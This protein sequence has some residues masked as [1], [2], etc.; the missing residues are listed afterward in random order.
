[1]RVLRSSPLYPVKLKLLELGVEKGTGNPEDYERAK[2]LLTRW[3]DK[4]PEIDYTGFIGFIADW[5]G[6]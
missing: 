5:V 6:V 4:H 1:M 2:R 3:V